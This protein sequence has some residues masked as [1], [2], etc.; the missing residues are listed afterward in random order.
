[1]RTLAALGM[2][3]P[4]AWLGYRQA[5][6]MADYR[7]SVGESRRIVL[8]DGSQVHLNTATDMDVRYS[9]HAR[10]LQLRRGEI[11]IQTAP[12]AHA[13]ARP[14]LVDRKTGVWG[15]GG[16]VRVDSGGRRL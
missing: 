5:G 15:K 16:S 1:M 8:A 10:L 9:E 3:L 4:A 13:L 6:G 2:A 7:T 14:F 11:Y 12:D